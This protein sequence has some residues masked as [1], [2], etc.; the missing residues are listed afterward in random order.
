MP[1]INSEPPPIEEQCWITTLREVI[2]KVE[3]TESSIED[4][5][6]GYQHMQCLQGIVNMIAGVPMCYPRYLFQSQQATSIKVR[7]ELLCVCWITVNVVFSLH[8][9]SC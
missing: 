5:Q 7:M 9:I 1:Q 2:D 4:G 6:L 8:E 3:Q